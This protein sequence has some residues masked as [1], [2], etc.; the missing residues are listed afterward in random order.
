MTLNKHRLPAFTIMEL[1]VAMLISAIVIAITFTAYSMVSSSYIDYTKKHN[2]LAVLIRLDE[3]LKKDFNKAGAV[4]KE[5]DG[6]KIINDKQIV[7]YRFEGEQVLR[8]AVITDTFKVA[9][10]NLAFSFENTS[11]LI[12]L[13]TNEEY[14]RVDELGFNVSYKEQNFPYHYSKQYSSENLINRNLNAVN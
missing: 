2:E 14:N 11:L 1:T 13:S 8:T 5:Q 6:I 9:A 7:K 12:E 4:Y 10:S 3:L